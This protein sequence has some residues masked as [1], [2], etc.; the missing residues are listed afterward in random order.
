MGEAL[1]FSAVL[2]YTP[3]WPKINFPVDVQNQFL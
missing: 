2:K 1:D 3:E